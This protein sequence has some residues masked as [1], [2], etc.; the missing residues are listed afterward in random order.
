MPFVTKL[1]EDTFNDIEQVVLNMKIVKTNR[2]N[3]EPDF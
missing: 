1:I 2:S 3:Y